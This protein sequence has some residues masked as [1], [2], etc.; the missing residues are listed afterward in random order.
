MREI[1]FRAYHKKYKKMFQLNFPYAS[2]VIKHEMDD[3]QV[4]EVKARLFFQN[5]EIMQYTGVKDRNKIDVYEG[6]ICNWWFCKSMMEA[7][8]KDGDKSYKYYKT[9]PFWKAWEVKWN[10]AGHN[11]T[12]PDGWYEPE[13]I[14]NIWENPEISKQRDKEI[15]NMD[16]SISAS[17][18]AED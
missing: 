1:K 13:I 6:D 14:G 11:W 4:F 17:P 15:E 9:H 7:K 2:D 5:C 16:Y 3:M 8:R 18:S 12:F 10:N